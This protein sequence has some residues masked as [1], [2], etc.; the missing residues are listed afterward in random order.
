MHEIAASGF[1]GLRHLAGRALRNQLDCYVDL[2]INRELAD[3]GPAIR[4][5]QTVLGAVFE[6]LVALTLRVFAQHNEAEVYHLRTKGG[7]HEIDFIVDHPTAILAVET[8]LATT[9]APHDTRHLNW[10]RDL[11]PGRPVHTAIITAGPEAHR[12]TD[13][14]AVI[15][16]GLLG[17]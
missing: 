9:I 2:I 11:I 1:P 15:P 4:R 12:A 8:K 16:L 3:A 10:L 13:G 5:P 14:T 17:P 6:S 7:R